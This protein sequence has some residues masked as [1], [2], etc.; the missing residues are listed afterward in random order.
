MVSFERDTIVTAGRAAEVIGLAAI[1]GGNLFARAGMHP[2]LREVSDP[3]ER[4]KVVNAAWRRYGT[5]E[6]LSLAALITGWASS[7]LGEA[8]CRSLSERQRRLGMAKDAAV[9]A[10]ALTGVAAAI[11]GIRFSGMEP[12]GA[13]PLEDGSKAGSSASLGESRA[14]QRLN[15]LGAVNL[16]SALTLAGVN[17]ALGQAKAT[18]DAGRRRCRCCLR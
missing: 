12:E 9:A 5:I 11:Q 7:R 1:I 15:L 10:V 8:D 2:A 16:A 14:K 13:V 17:A 18:E 3:A 4:G 6:S